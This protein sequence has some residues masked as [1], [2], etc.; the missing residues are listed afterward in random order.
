ML[1]CVLL[2]VCVSMGDVGVVVWG[3]GDSGGGGVCFVGGGVRD[4]YCCSCWKACV[5]LLPHLQHTLPPTKPH[6]HQHHHR[7]HPTTHIRPT[8]HNTKQHTTQQQHKH[9]C[10]VQCAV[11]SK[12]NTYDFDHKLIGRKNPHGCFPWLQILIG[13]PYGPSKRAGAM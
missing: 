12:P 1:V 2:I 7:H 8:T 6:Y 5:L 11:E 10:T 4:C 13:P 3:G 9:R